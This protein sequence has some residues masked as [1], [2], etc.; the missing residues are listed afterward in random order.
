MN[1][2][3][4]FYIGDVPHTGK[5]LCG[6]IKEGLDVFLSI[7]IVESDAGAFNGSYSGK[8]T[9]TAAAAAKDVPDLG[10]K[11]SIVGEAFKEEFFRSEEP[12]GLV[13]MVPTRIE[14]VFSA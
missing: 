6:T 10:E 12:H 4:T 8:K 14:L 1:G 7:L 2:D 5:D 3:I 9:H 11:V 13:K